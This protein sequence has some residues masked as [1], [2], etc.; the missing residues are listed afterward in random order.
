[1]MIVKPGDEELILEAKSLRKTTIQHN[2]EFTA[3]KK[4]CGIVR[5]AWNHAL[6]HTKL[7]LDINS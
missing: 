5:H 7:I 2:A 4:H 6:A 1:M 3:F